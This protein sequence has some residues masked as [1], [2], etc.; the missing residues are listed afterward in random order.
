M[1]SAFFA[2]R[3]G[4]RAQTA[5]TDA[6]GS[7]PD[8]DSASSHIQTGVSRTRNGCLSPSP[9]FHALS[10]PPRA[11][12]KGGA[13]ALRYA[14]QYPAAQDEKEADGGMKQTTRWASACVRAWWVFPTFG[15]PNFSLKVS[16]GNA[17]L[18]LHNRFCPVV[19]C[20]GCRSRLQTLPGDSYHIMP[21][22]NGFSD[23]P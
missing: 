20:L 21:K 8:R 13:G 15:I 19:H 14:S 9:R 18:C 5:R 17:R 11:V 12:S 2:P 16:G 7:R 1:P 10:R 22:R 3:T 4:C 23:V 6:P